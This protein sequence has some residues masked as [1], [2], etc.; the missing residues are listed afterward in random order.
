VT[1]QAA[2]MKSMLSSSDGEAASIVDI[3]KA[4]GGPPIPSLTLPPIE[5][6][7][8]KDYINEA[9]YYIKEEEDYAKEKEDYIKEK[10]PAYRSWE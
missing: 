2:K 1:Q 9:E 3:W 8:E 4:Q 5:V 6:K 10:N 7:Q